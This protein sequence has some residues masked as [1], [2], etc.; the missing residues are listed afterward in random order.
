VVSAGRVTARDFTGYQESK[1]DNF[2]F[3]FSF[4]DVEHGPEY[5]RPQNG[6]RNKNRS[7]HTRRAGSC[8]VLSAVNLKLSSQYQ[9]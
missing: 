4:T 3:F 2:L 5:F 7:G 1:P 8:L 6:V 9:K